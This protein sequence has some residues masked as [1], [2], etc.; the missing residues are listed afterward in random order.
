MPLIDRQEIRRRIGLE[1]GWIIEGN[2][3][4]NGAADGS[5]ILDTNL[6]SDARD[7]YVRNR[8]IIAITSGD[9]RGDRRPTT[10]GLGS[11][12]VLVASPLF[13]AQIVSGV[14]YEIWVADGPHPDDI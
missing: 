14:S 7:Q 11:D 3:T 12:G 5:T 13:G 2:L 4:A 1:N 8:D 9:R 10:G 6:Y